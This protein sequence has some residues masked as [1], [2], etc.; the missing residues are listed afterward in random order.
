VVVVEVHGY[1]FP[2]YSPGI[3]FLN[4]KNGKVTQPTLIQDY[5]F[6]R[7][8]WSSDGENFLLQ[9][10]AI[11][12]IS[13]GE[14]KIS[15][16]IE[17][18][19]KR[20]PN[21]E[22]IY[23]YWS[24]T[25][26]YIILSKI[27]ASEDPPIIEVYDAETGGRV[28]SY[29]YEPYT[30]YGSLSYDDKYMTLH[31]RRL[32]NGEYSPLDPY[33]IYI[34]DWQNNKVSQLTDNVKWE[35]PINAYGGL[36]AFWSP[37]N[38]HLAIITGYPT[39][40]YPDGPNYGNGLAIYDISTMQLVAEYIGDLYKE[41]DPDPPNV[42]VSS[43]SQLTWSPDGSKIA[44]ANIQRTETGRIKSDICILTLETGIIDCPTKRIPMISDSRLNE[45]PAWTSDGNQILFLTTW[46]DDCYPVSIMDVD[47]S[48][49]HIINNELCTMG[50]EGI[51]VPP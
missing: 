6:Y 19:Q 24:T 48:N 11:L 5:G 3:A 10:P 22:V 50:Y 4:I 23:G 9:P 16:D 25:G 40:P 28:R 20:D 38:H 46:E 31:K 32:V 33:D 14:I 26:Q 18:I 29:P 37:I 44:F 30:R 41:E 47:G 13:S 7:I 34:W 21:I 12:N 51:L 27:F 49:F 35:D 45:H 1:N 15:L 42:P 2:K 36:A 43:F 39:I 17:E 8:E